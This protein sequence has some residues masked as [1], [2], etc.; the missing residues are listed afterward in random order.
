MS[1]TSFFS[2]P[3]SE[4]SSFVFSLEIL[5][6]APVTNR[7]SLIFRPRYSEF[8]NR[9]AQQRNV[10]SSLIERR[11]I[12]RR[13][14]RTLVLENYLKMPSAQIFILTAAALSAIIELKLTAPYSECALHA[15]GTIIKMRFTQGRN[16]DRKDGS[17]GFIYPTPRSSDSN[18]S[19]RSGQRFK[20]I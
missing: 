12:T 17:Y 9:C 16:D 2:P 11:A 4:S 5:R 13:I 15:R 6:A 3:T 20:R 14:S 19:M 1:S 18:Y 7:K 8:Y 10:S